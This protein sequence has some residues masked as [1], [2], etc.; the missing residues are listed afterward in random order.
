MVPPSLPPPRPLADP[1]PVQLVELKNGETFNGH[2]VGCDNF[3]N[4]TLKEVYQ[5]SA[6]RS[7]GLATTGGEADWSSSG[8]MQDGEQF[9]KLPECYVRGNN[10]RLYRVT[11]RSP[12]LLLPP[13]DQVHPCGRERAYSCFCSWAGGD[14]AN[15][16]AGNS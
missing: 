1:L 6:V 12:R 13:P 3:M 11:S 8:D 14:D 9:W 15:A 5:T 10:V 7:L 16:G 2:L 4:L